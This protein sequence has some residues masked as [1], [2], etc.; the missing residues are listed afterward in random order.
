M[1]RFVCTDM[2]AESN[3]GSGCQCAGCQDAFG[4][5]MLGGPAP[6][7]ANS[8]ADIPGDSTTDISLVVGTPVT[9]VLE[10]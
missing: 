8:P 1:P 7:P 5:A 9:G 6:S 2:H 3:L 10:V 4:T